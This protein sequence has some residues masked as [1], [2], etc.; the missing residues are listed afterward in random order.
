MK[1][2][3]SKSEIRLLRE[4][5]PAKLRKWIRDY[6]DILLTWLTSHYPVDP[7]QAAERTGQIFHTAFAQLSRYDPSDSSMYIWLIRQAESMFPKEAFLRPQAPAKVLRAL[8]SIGSAEIPDAYLENPTVIRLVQTA[9][10]EMDEA[11]RKALLRRYYRIDPGAGAK[12]EPQ[13]SS[14]SLGDRLVR[15]RYYFRRN[16]LACI[17]ALQPDLGQLPTD[18]RIPV[19]EKNLEIIFRSVPPVLKLPD[20]FVEELEKKLLQEAQQIQTAAIPVKTAWSGRTLWIAV[21]VVLLVLLA[22]ISYLWPGRTEIEPVFGPKP[23]KNIQKPQPSDLQMPPQNPSPEELKKY[24]ARVFEAG[25]SNDMRELFRALED[26][27]Y[28]V[29]VAAAIFLGRIGDESAIG[30]LE[31]ASRLRHPSPLEENPFLTAIDQIEQRLTLEAQRQ[32]EEAFIEYNQAQESQPVI[33][34]ASL[35]A[36]PNKKPEIQEVHQTSFPLPEDTQDFSD[37]PEQEFTNEENLD[38]QQ[39]QQLEQEEVLSEE[40]GRP[41]DI[42]EPEEPNEYEEALEDEYATDEVQ[43]IEDQISQDQY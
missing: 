31:K 21:G 35:P 39:E 43:Y 8:G 25:S 6:G 9:V 12:L 27:P 28:P 2:N 16:L 11:E 38:Q 36:E 3:W 18:S 33:A 14:D 37:L 34:Q 23:N 42:E 7:E 1:P 22:A 29:Q 4:A 20:S 30:P 15:A 19:L 5:N 32:E 26:G 17:Y 41:S 40:E 13:F 24:M 10:T